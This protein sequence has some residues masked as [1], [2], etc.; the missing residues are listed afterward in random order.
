MKNTN[1]EA[2]DFSP[3]RIDKHFEKHAKEF[4]DITV[5]MY[6]KQAKDLLNSETNDN[7]LGF[8]SENGFIFRYD[9]AKNEFATS[10]P[11]GV[12]ETYFKPKN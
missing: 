8:K 5:K 9:K 12:I 10:K 11:S 3:K 1:W 4:E 2:V 6:I 7:I